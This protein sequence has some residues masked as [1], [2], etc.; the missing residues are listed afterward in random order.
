MHKHA[1]TFHTNKGYKWLWQFSCQFSCFHKRNLCKLFKCYLHKNEAL[2]F[3]TFYMKMN[4][5][6][7]VF[8][9]A[10]DDDNISF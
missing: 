10:E 3:P 5:F 6:N 4:H 7:A 2:R 8:H 9:M 1:E